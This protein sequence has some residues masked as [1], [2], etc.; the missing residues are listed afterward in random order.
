VQYWVDYLNAGNPE[1]TKGAM[2][3]QMLRDVHTW[4]E[5]ITDPL[6]PNYMWHFVADLLNNKAAL[7][8]YYAVEQG[9]SMNVQADNIDFGIELAS[10]ITPDDITAA[11]ALIGVN[12]FSVL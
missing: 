10:L 9:L 5:P 4:F 2:V 1:Q 12:T 6:D 11:I 3:L 8:N 7:A